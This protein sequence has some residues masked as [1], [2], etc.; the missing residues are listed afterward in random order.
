ML[1]RSAQVARGELASGPRVWDWSSRRLGTHSSQVLCVADPGCSPTLD[2]TSHLVTQRRDE[3]RRRR[4]A[5][6][7]WDESLE[8][9]RCVGG[10][11]CSTSPCPFSR[12]LFR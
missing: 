8:F 10:P 12:S 11:L 6:F 9:R 4:Y 2:L 5:R 7:S 3:S 1:H